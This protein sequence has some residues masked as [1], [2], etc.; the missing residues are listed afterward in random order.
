MKIRWGWGRKYSTTAAFFVGIA[1]LLAEPRLGL[2]QSSDSAT[3]ELLFQEALGLMAKGDFAAACPRL[4]QSS[5]LDPGVGVLLYLGDCQEKQGKTATAWATFRDAAAT[6]RRANQPEREKMGLD[7]ATALESTMPRL[8]IEI[9]QNV[10]GLVIRRDGKEIPTL[11]WNKA[12]PVDP[13]TYTIE[14]SAPGKTNFSVTVTIEKGGATKTI[15]IEPLR[16]AIAP[17]PPPPPPPPPLLPPLPPPA[18]RS[19]G[20]VGVGAIVLTSAGLLTMGGSL[21]VGLLAQSKFDESTP[22]CDGRYCDRQGVTLRAEALDMASVGTGVFIAGAITT[23]IGGAVFVWS[24]ARGSSSP[25][26]TAP[27][28]AL[29]VGPGMLTIRGS[30]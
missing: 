29:V 11:L 10:A 9:V 20:P 4:E 21:V 5:K 1:I 7:R 25:K 19:L 13:G 27:K 23:G 6:A 26:E 22:H 15:P 18:P 3:A 24:L 30:F 28:A 17:P 14:A 12:F 16:D 2:C 8:Q